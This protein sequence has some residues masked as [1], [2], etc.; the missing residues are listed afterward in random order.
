MPDELLS[1]EE[2][3]LLLSLTQAECLEVARRCR[4]KANLYLEKAKLF[5]DWS[6]NGAGDAE[7]FRRSKSRP[8]N[9]IN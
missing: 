4:E 7:G 8:G 6:K 3:R 5:T 2:Q 1:E 9:G